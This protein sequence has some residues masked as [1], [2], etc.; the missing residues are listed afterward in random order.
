[1]VVIEKVVVCGQS[2]YIPEKAVVFWQ[3]WLYS[4]RRGCIRDKVVAFGQSGCYRS[5]WLY[6]DNVVVF[7][8]SGCI[9]EEGVVIGHELLYSGKVVVVEE[10]DCIRAK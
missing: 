10:S 9:R 4:C 2:C 8:Q 6:S 5:K 1:M 3:K 7:G